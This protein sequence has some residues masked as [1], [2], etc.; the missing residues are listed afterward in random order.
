MLC[1]DPPPTFLVECMTANPTPKYFTL[2]LVEAPGRL[3]LGK[4]KRQVCTHTMLQ[5][6]QAD[7]SAAR[8]LITC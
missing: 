5:H 7:L 1:A 2:T 8:L 3:L 6:E 4:K